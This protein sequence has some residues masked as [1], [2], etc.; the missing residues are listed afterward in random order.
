M[1]HVQDSVIIGNR[2]TWVLDADHKSHRC[3]TKM[4]THFCYKMVQCGTWDWCIV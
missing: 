4:G 2:V 1:V 3:V